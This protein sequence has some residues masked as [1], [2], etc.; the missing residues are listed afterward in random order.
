MDSE[1]VLRSR[2]SFITSQALTGGISIIDAYNSMIAF[3]S[4]VKKLHSVVLNY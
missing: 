3:R 1:E 4:F 2:I